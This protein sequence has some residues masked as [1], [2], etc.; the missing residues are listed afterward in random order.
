MIDKEVSRKSGVTEEELT[1]LCRS[2]FS[3]SDGSRLLVALCRYRHPMANRFET[4]DHI[5]AAI[6]DGE[7]GVIAW[8]VRNAEKPDK[9]HA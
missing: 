7:A 5:R 1:S 9:I 4:S 8:L 3:G 2:V 6:R